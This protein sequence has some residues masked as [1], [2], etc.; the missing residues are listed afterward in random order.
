[1]MAL[2]YCLLII[3]IIMFFYYYFHFCYERR[4]R[5]SATGVEM[6]IVYAIAHLSVTRSNEDKMAQPRARR[7]VRTASGHVIKVGVRSESPSGDT[8]KHYYESAP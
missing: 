2:N 4:H 1:M 6:E 3:I 7:F 5:H 8:T